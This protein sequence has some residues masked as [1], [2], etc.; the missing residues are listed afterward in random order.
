MTETR[1][2]TIP[3]HD[4]ASHEHHELR[5]GLDRI[6]EVGSLSGTTDELSVAALEVLH[7]VESVLVPHA[8]WEDSWL[9]P[10]IDQRAGTPWATKLMSFEHQQIRDTASAV[11]AARTTLRQTRTPAAMIELRAQ[12]FAL[13]AVIRAHMAREE[14]FLIPMLEPPT[15][16][17]ASRT[18]RV[19]TTSPAGVD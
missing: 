11:A 5:H 18:S 14:R 3:E 12:L 9:Y 1:R 17:A 6:H 4:F 16:E 19:G 8:H 2:D 13:E 15:V 10:E 7:W